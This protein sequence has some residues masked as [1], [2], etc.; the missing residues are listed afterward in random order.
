MKDQNSTYKLSNGVEIPCIGF[1]MWQ[2]PDDE[3]GVNSVLSAI[4]AGY[5]HIDTAQAYGNERGV[6]EGIRASGLPRDR[7]FVTSKVAAELKDYLVREHRM[8]IR[9]ASNFNGL[10]ARHF[11]VASQTP[12]ENDALVAAINQFLAN[13]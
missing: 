13:G 12:E 7:I 4:K 5:R 3:V 11:R 10:T 9:D 1:G 6:G 8:L 2:T